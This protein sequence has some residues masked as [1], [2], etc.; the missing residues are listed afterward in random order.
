MRTKIDEVVSNFIQELRAKYPAIV[1]KILDCKSPHVDAYLRVKCASHDQVDDV[2][3]TVAH[4]TTKYY[5]DEGVYIQGSASF[6]GP[7][8]VEHKGSVQA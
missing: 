1:V 4:L 7:L 8:P 5:L 3:E 2:M 6:A